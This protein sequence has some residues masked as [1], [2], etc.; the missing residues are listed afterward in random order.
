VRTIPI[1]KSAESVTLTYADDQNR[2]TGIKG[3]MA[4]YWKAEAD[5]MTGTKPKLRQIKLE[6]QELYAFAYATDKSLRNAPIALGAWLQAGMKEAVDFKIGDSIVNGDGAGKPRGLLVSPD[7]VS[8]AKETSQGAA[9]FTAANAAKMWKRMPAWMRGNA[10]WLMNQDCE[11]QLDRMAAS[12]IKNDG[13]TLESADT[14]PVYNAANNTLKGRPVVFCEY[15]ATL[16][17]VGDIIL[18]APQHYLVATKAGQGPEMSM[19]L[20]FDYAE[21]AFRVIFE[22]DGKSEFPTVFTPYK[23]SIT[24]APIVT[25]DTRS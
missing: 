25:L 14:P 17:T 12:V 18:W 3:G 6:P 24:R 2:T 7:K 1:D 21:T 8:V 20:R 9:T 16:G 22:V 5:Q 19:H 10:I 11:E 23:G 4:A 13:T 15:C